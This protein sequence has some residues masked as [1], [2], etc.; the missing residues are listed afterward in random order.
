MISWVV[1]DINIS[2]LKKAM[3]NRRVPKPASGTLSGHAAGEPFDKLVYQLIKEKYPNKTFRQY[4]YLNKLYLDHPKVTTYKDRYSLISS[5]ALRL[6]LNRGVGVT[7]KW[8]STNQLKEKQD[9]TA[10]T[11]LISGNFHHI[12]DVKTRNIDKK[13]LAP[14]IISAK[15]L[16]EMSLIMIKETDFDS[17]KITYVGVDWALE[18]AYLVCSKTTMKDIFQATPSSLYINWSAANQIQFHVE[19]LDQS[20]KKG[21]K[22]WC[23]EYLAHYVESANHRMKHFRK[24]FIKPFDID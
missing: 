15:K 4:E 22:T 23:K 21:I 5:P 11:L 7:K 13:A 6:L 19:K 17:F 9:D 16:A 12:I 8:T 3:V 14:N 10:D 1:D 24:K 20:Y 18:G 2:F